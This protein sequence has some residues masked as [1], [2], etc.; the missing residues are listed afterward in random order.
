MASYGRR[1]SFAVTIYDPDARAG[2]GW[3]HWMV[4]NIPATVHALAAGAGSEGSKD[5]PAGAGQGRND[6]GVLQYSGPCPPAGDHAHHYE[7]TVHAVKVARLPLD[8]TASG[9]EVSARCVP[10]HWPRPRS[11]DATRGGTDGAFRLVWWA[12][13]P[14]WPRRFPRRAKIG[15][16]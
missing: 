3:W 5:F 15:W 16:I 4:F 11:S 1:E 14:R 13:Q 2:G 7:I 8:N 12:V 6:F 10:T 9:A